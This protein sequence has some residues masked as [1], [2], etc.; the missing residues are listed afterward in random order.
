MGYHE[1]SSEHERYNTTVDSE[2]DGG[3]LG[4]GLSFA[5]ASRLP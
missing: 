1:N 5:V 2:V 4:S 3:V